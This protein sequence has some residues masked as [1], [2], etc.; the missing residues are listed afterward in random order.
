MP[1]EGRRVVRRADVAAEDVRA[2]AEAFREVATAI[3]RLTDVVEEGLS[4]LSSAVRLQKE[5]IL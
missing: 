4:D 3:E 1:R 2:L 5:E